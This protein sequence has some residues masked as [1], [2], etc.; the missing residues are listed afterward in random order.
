M[1]IFLIIP[2]LARLFIWS[3]MKYTE[4][5]IRELEDKIF[6]LLNPVYGYIQMYTGKILPEE[7][8]NIMLDNLN[9]IE[10]FIRGKRHISKRWNG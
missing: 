6:N 7:K 9:K 2:C 8:A 10:I 1:G 3:M 5:Q 4:D